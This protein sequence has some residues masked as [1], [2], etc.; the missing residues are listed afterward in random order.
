MSERHEQESLY[1]RWKETRSE[2]DQEALA[3][4]LW[5]YASRII[6]TMRGV[7]DRALASDIVAAAFRREPQFRGDSKFT[8]W[9]YRLAYNLILNA[10]RDEKARRE[11]SLDCYPEPE[12]TETPELSILLEQLSKRLL[13]QDRLILQGK[14]EGTTDAELAAE[15]GMGIEGVRSRWK[16]LKKRLRQQLSEA[17]SPSEKPSGSEVE[18][19]TS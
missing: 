17:A 2:V 18:S 14:F 7:E 4:S 19:P 15:L 13:P 3:R 16:K 8:T 9:F 6:G 10:I 11:W 12:V 1:R 5:R